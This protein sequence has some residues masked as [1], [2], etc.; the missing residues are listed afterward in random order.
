MIDGNFNF[1]RKTLKSLVFV[2]ITVDRSALVEFLE[3]DVDFV[4]AAHAAW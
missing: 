4:I 2:V 3:M 1:F